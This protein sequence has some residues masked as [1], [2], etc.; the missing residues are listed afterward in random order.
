MRGR[1]SSYILSLLRVKEY[2]FPERIMTLLIFYHPFVQ[3]C[4]YMNFNKNQQLNGEKYIPIYYSKR[5]TADFFLE[6]YILTSPLVQ[7]G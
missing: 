6:I 1:Q 7:E 4:L 5:I 3:I 2:R